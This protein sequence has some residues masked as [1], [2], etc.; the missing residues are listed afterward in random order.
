MPVGLAAGRQSV[1]TFAVTSHRDDPLLVSD[2]EFSITSGPSEEM[3]FGCLES[4]HVEMNAAPYSWSVMIT[5]NA[6]GGDAVSARARY[7]QS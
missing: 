2:I 1:T 6:P 7:R 4:L 3:L 5:C